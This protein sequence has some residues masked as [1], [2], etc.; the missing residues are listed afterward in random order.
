MEATD[1]ASVI[2]VP[3]FCAEAGYDLV[4]HSHVGDVHRFRIRRT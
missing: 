2:D 1:P 4:E 3:H